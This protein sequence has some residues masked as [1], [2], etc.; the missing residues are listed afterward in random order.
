[1]AG[2]IKVNFS[3]HHFLIAN[4]LLDAYTAK[5]NHFTYQNLSYRQT[6]LC[7]CQTA[8]GPHDKILEKNN[9]KEE[10]FILVHGFGGFI[11]QPL[12]SMFLGL[13]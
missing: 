7:V 1:M 10:R 4:R 2:T 11:P 8:I 3:G 13:W 9:L 12:G 5:L 6:Q